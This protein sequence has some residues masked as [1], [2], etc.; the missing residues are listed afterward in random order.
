MLIFLL[1]YDNLDI[2]IEAG[3]EVARITQFLSEEERGNIVLKQVINMAHDEQNEDNKVV[4]VQLFGKLA[5]VFGQPLIESFVAFEILSM[6]EDMKQSIRKETVLQL[7]K[8][9]KLVNFDFFKTR[10]LPFYFKYTLCSISSSSKGSAKKRPGESG[11]AA[12]R[13]LSKYPTFAPWKSEP[14][15]SQNRCSPF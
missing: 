13:S 2:K 8:V 7:A 11:S 10:L 5:A 3:N 4:A 15:N 6:G 14:K 12:L 9:G 1:N